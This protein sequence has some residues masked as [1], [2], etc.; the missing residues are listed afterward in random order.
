MTVRLILVLFL[1][2][3]FQ[4]VN[5][6]VDNFSNDP[7]KF[8]EQLGKHLG[9]FDKKDSKM[10]VEEFTPVWNGMK[11]SDQSQVVE[12]CNLIQ[13]KR[14]RIYPEFKGYIASVNQIFKK[15]LGSDVFNSWNDV[16][17]KVMSQ[18]QKKKMSEFL[19]NSGNF[20]ATEQFFAN[21]KLSWKA[22]GGS[23]KYGYDKSPFIEFTDVNLVCYANKD[24]SII[25]KTSGKFRPYSAEFLG[26]GGEIHMTRVKL[27]P[28]ETRGEFT[29]SYKINVKSSTYQIDS[30]KFYNTYFKE[31]LWGKI[32]EKVLRIGSGKEATYPRFVSYSKRLLIKEIAP[33]VDYEGGFTMHGAV[34]KGSG[35]A[36]EPAILTFYRNNKPFVQTSAIDYNIKSDKISSPIASFKFIMEKDSLVHPG[37]NLEY[38]YK[39]KDKPAKLTIIRNKEGVGMSPFVNSYHNIDMY[40]ESM[41]WV[42]GDSILRMGPLFGSSKTDAVFE[43]SNFFDRR[44]FDRIG[45][46]S[47]MHPMVAIARHAVRFDQFE[48]TTANLATALGMAKGPELTRLLYQLNNNNFIRYDQKNEYVYIKQK[49]FDYIDNRMG[50]KDYDNIVI[51]SDPKGKENANL[52]VTSYELDI[53]GISKFNLSESQF[54]QAFPKASS[55]YKDVNTGKKIPYGSIKMYKNRNIVFDGTVIAGSTDYFGTDFNF[56]YEDFKITIPQCDSMKIWVWPFEGGKNQRPLRS[57]IED[58]KGEID[59]DDPSNRAGLDTSFNYY[60]VLKCTKESYVF[61]DKISKGAYPRETFMF[62]IKPFTL[63]SLDNFNRDALAFEGS[64]LS[65]GIFPEFD[66]K[67]K[68]LT[69]YSLGFVRDLPKEGFSLYEDRGQF[70]NSIALTADGLVGDGIIEFVK[71]TSVSKAFVFY[72]DSTSGIVDSFINEPQGKPIE[73][74]DVKGYGVKITFKPK[75]QVLDA[76][77][78][79]KNLLTFFKN[80]STMKGKISITAQE[81]TGRGKMQFGNADLK[82]R[83]FTY[84][85]HKVQ[86][87]TSEFDLESLQKEDN[88][89]AFKTDNVSALVDFKAREGLFKSNGENSYVEFPENQYICYMDE[90]KWYMDNDDIELQKKSDLVVESTE[91]EKPNFYSIHP[92]QDSLSFMAP[93]ARYDLR[94]KTITCTEVPFMDIADARIVPDSGTVIIKKKAKIQTLENAMIIADNVSKNHKIINVTCDVMAKRSYKASGDYFYVDEDEK[95]FKIHFAKIEPDSSF[96]TYA[97]GEIKQEENFSLSKNFEFFGKVELYAINK[98]LVFD[99]ATRIT[100]ACDQVSKNWMNFRAQIDPL[101]IYIP[102]GEEMKDMDNKPIGAGIIMNPSVDSLGVY[103]TFLSRKGSN[104]HPNVISAQGFLHF[105]KASKEYRIS[106][107]E[108]LQERSLPGNYVSLQTDNC[109]IEGDGTITYGADLGQLSATS[110]GV[111]TH[112]MN[113]GEVRS[114]GGMFLDFPFSESALKKIAEKIEKSPELIPVELGKTFYKKALTETLDKDRAEEIVGEV[115]LKGSIKGKFPKELQKSFFIADVKLKWNDE[116]S[117]F[118]SEGLIGIA[119]IQKDQIYKYVNGKIAIQ[120]RTPDS[121]GKSKDKMY[122]YLELDAANWYY[123]EYSNNARESILEVVSSDN[124]FN[125]EILETK[126]DKAKYKGEKGQPDFRFIAGRKSKRSVFLSQFE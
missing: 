120:K 18:K 88:A 30:V 49:L 8:I 126:E 81:M 1:M 90:F 15:G 92:K 39:T 97:D 37:I 20:F 100:H 86:S 78:V 109:V 123:F 2:T 115:T 118:V 3:G 102:V 117:A 29:S 50:K 6:Q 110:V 121:K 69:D 36:K 40:V 16:V 91:F 76:Y 22:K 71:S 98:S 25:R 94:K 64:L 70:K 119:N 114:S 45:N 125:N 108:K 48:Y 55:S 85:E 13:K 82:A 5:A 51:Y 75:S 26:K 34:F 23:F 38:Q 122:I 4:F 59:I 113:S 67:L 41:S 99:G 104:S 60:P 10:F 33:E 96:T 46:T 111:I 44:K 31:P 7:E 62:K 52:N 21:T 79:D 103:S 105:D 24:S 89:L 80:E 84:K 101:E 124:D 19:E 11:A 42:R 35:T 112:N 47:Q 53:T 58:I 83:K 63:D 72:P 56:D 12:A 116:M 93:K 43:S 14:L 107:K 61:Y 32:N 9:S 57:V 68:V 77:S 54:V 65:A 74:P 106:N 17:K 73:F 66:E 27:D 28:S 87:D 95:E